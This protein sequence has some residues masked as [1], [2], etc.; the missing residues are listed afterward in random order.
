MSVST[1]RWLDHDAEQA[2]RSAELVKALQEPDTVDSLGVGTIRDGFANVF[3]PGT[4]TIQ[5]RARYFLLTPWALQKVDQQRPRDRAQYDRYLDD[6][7]TA[8]IEAL[9]AGNPGE[10]GIIGSQRRR[11]TKRKAVSVYW[12]G[13][14]EWGVRADAGMTMASHREYVL[15]RNRRTGGG[16]DDEGATPYQVWDEIP[17]TPPGFPEEPTS[18][19][20]SAFEAE[21]L[22]ARMIGTTAGGLGSP[23]VAAQSLLGGVAAQPH[24]ADVVWPWEVPASVVPS[25]LREAL[26]HAHMFSLVIQGAR[27]LYVRLL[28]DRQHELGLG[29]SPGRE[30]VEARLETWLESMENASADAAAWAASL[31]DMFG[32][33]GGFGIVVGE[34]TRT[35]VRAWCASAVADPTVA[36]GSAQTLRLLDAR[37]RALKGPLARLAGGPALAAWDGSQFGSAQLDYRWGTAR[38]MVF[39]CREGMES[40]RVGS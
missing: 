19:L 40:D 24:V 30:D 3:F 32:L 17:P 5:T 22:L 26:H 4:S 38:R 13:L 6:A 8:T 12:T 16:A 1:L 29:E 37:E 10:F 34:A 7:E 11:A 21:Y 28:F 33:L 39:D 31:D 9:L 27:L 35:F 2:R 15:T 25:A 14:G 20:P 18:I 23:H 36:L